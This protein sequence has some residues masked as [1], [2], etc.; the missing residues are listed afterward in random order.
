MGLRIV[1]PAAGYVSDEGM[2]GLGDEVERLI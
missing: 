2:V 1:I